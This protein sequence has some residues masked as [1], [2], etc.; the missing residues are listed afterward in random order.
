MDGFNV[1][2]LNMMVIHIFGQ[3]NNLM[4]IPMYFNEG[5]LAPLAKYKDKDMKS[6]RPIMVN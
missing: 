5:S 6:I 3:L 4:K 1:K 2:S